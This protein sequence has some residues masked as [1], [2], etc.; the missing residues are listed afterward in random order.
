MTAPGRASRSFAAPVI[1]SLRTHRVF[2]TLCLLI[3]VNQLGFGLITPVLPLYADS[4]GLGPSMIGVV[5]GV[6]GLARFAVNLP[7]GRLAERIGRRP[8]L[9]GGTIITAVSAALMA[10]AQNLPQL[11]LYRVLGGAGAATVLVAGQIMVTD[12]STPS[13]RARLSSVYQ[14][15]FLI[16]VGLGPLPGGV[17]ADALGLRVPFIVYSLC[18]GLACLW[19]TLT[20]AET[21]PATAAVVRPL[22]EPAPGA[23]VRSIVFSVGFVLVSAV[24][25][26]Q[27][28]ARTGALFN[29]VPLMG[30][31]RLGLSPAQIGL[32]LTLVNVLNIATLYHSGALS[33]RFGRKPVIW[34]STV[35][36]GLSLLA[37]A[38]SG[39]YLAFI[40]SA[41]LWGLASGI[42]GPSPGAYIADL[43]PAAQRGRLIGIYRTCADAGYVVGPLLLGW[44]VGVA[45]FSAP[46]VLTAALFV[47]SG[48]LFAL[49]APETHPRA[50]RGL[51]PERGRE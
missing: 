22:E 49:L 6:Y 36:S 26:V 37:F 29:V 10:T 35:I 28:F 5:I 39:G 24:T 38:W 15:F 16:G 20:L 33:D 21:W 50:L 4:F 44:L 8:V 30:R 19:A 32:A 40:G 25:F 1:S 12:L 46:L 11:L 18:A 31:E 43:A 17:L 3:L 2:L 51:S 13:N 41:L 48:M 42:S 7:A 47:L 27:F 34:P 45:G 9:I 23:A 14:G